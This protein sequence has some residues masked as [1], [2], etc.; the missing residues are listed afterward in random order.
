MSVLTVEELRAVRGSRRWK[1]L[2]VELCPPGS[3][4]GICLGQRGPIR[5][6]LRA[7]HSLGP[8]LDHIVSPTLGGDPW[9]P[10]NLQPAHF[11]CN[12]GKRDRL[13]PSRSLRGWVW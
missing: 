1:A 11:G 5:F 4:C 10:S 7:R 12:S 8:S 2:V 6:G 13:P 9:D 3:V